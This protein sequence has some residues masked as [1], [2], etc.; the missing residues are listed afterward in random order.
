LV[1]VQYHR[2]L[3]HPLVKSRK[4]DGSI[5]NFSSMWEFCNADTMGDCSSNIAET[6]AVLDSPQH[7]YGQ[8]YLGS[9]CD[10]HWISVGGGALILFLL[11]VT[12]SIP[13]G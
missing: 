7:Q 1:V 3:F 6:M 4:H 11:L 2:K 5:V 10:G 12:S 13:S 8:P 9:P